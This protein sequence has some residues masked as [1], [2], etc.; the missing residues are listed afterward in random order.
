MELE[1]H[2]VQLHEIQN[3]RN[4]SLRENTFQFVHDKCHGAG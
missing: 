1:V 2:K 3:L 4:L